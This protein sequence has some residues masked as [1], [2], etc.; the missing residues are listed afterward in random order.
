MKFDI[1]E[2]DSA[3][4]INT[5]G[6]PFTHYQIRKEQKVHEQKGHYKTDPSNPF[7]CGM[8]PYEV[9]RILIIRLSSFA[10]PP[11]NKLGEGGISIP[12]INVFTS[13]LSPSHVTRS[14]AWPCIR[15][16]HCVFSIY[17]FFDRLR[18]YNGMI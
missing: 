5:F 4:S 3:F 16:I 6:N 7:V 17:W 18:S 1:A 13:V 2:D 8:F 10:L 12:G 11:V 14:G 9:T 15:S